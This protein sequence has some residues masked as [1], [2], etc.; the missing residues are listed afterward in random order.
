MI[1]KS[2]KFVTELGHSDHLKFTSALAK[3]KS[4]LANDLFSETAAPMVL[5]FQVQH[6]VAAGLQDGEIQPGR[7]SKNGRCC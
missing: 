2:K 3:F 5:K 1:S 4:T 6:N 7:E